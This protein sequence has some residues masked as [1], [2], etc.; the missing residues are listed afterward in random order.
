[1]LLMAKM[2]RKARSFVRCVAHFATAMALIAASAIADDGHNRIV[3]ATYLPIYDSGLAG[4]A[5]DASGNTY[6]A[7]NHLVAAPAV[8]D[9]PF[10]VESFIARVPA[11]GGDQEVI[12]TVPSASA[13]A[14]LRDASG[15]FY[16][17][18]LIAWTDGFSTTAGAFQTDSG[19]GFVAKLDGAGKLLWASRISA[20]PAALALDSAGNVYVTGTAKSDFRTTQGAFKTA[21][22]EARCDPYAAVTVPCTDAF[23][24]KISPDGTRLLYATFVGGTLDDSAR[25]VAVDSTGSAYIAGQTLSPDFPTTPGAFQPHYGDG[26]SPGSI[27]GDGFAARLSPDGSKLIYSTFM[28]G[29]GTDLA[30][31]LAVDAGQ[32]A[33]ILGFTLSP[34]F[35]VTPNAWQKNY[36]DG[37]VPRTY[38]GDAFYLKLDPTGK[39][40]YASFLGGPNADYGGPVGLAG[41]RV[42]LTVSGLVAASLEGRTPG[43]CEPASTLVLVDKDSGDVVDHEGLR[44]V[45]AWGPNAGTV[46]VDRSGIIHVAGI[47][48]RVTDPFAI[49]TAAVTTIGSGFLIRVDFSKE[50]DF[51]PQC[52][53]NAASFASRRTNAF[54][55]DT[56]SVAPGEMIAIF[57]V[58]LAPDST[59][60]SNIRVEIGGRAIPVISA[61]SREILASVPYDLQPGTNDFRVTRGD[62]TSAA[63]P[64]AIGPVFPGVFTMDGSGTGQAAVLNQDG[65]V[66]SAGNPAARGSTVSVYATGLGAVSPELTPLER[67]DVYISI[68]EKMELLW[69]GVAP[70]LPAGAFQLNLRVP[71]DASAPQMLLKLAYDPPGW[72]RSQDGVFVWVK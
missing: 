15:A 36:G 60:A 3:Y 7:G 39:A 59:A 18:G 47:T 8:A 31:G 29:S 11:A 32:N 10:S 68:S 35:P 70:D 20:Q 46:A 13:T 51:V 54:L 4:I 53:L 25:A 45:Q 63:Y 26:P 61:D 56:L 67:F 9:W 71:V 62:R 19:G 37:N 12:G 38:G 1:M 55:Q 24:A 42:A 44:A 14:M 17:A 49:S 48:P 58:Q 66:N 72:D 21:I 16:L 34:G 50:D 57:G 30:T 52:L 2:Q 28:G 43:P 5:V 69:V 41:D 40:V 27:W 22:G 33:Y 23:A 65:T 6:Y 64:V